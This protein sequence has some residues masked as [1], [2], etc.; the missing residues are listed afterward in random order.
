MM[1]LTIT[2]VI[3]TIQYLKYLESAELPVDHASLLGSVSAGGGIQGFCAGL[4]SA[5]AVASGTTKEEVAELA[6][7]SVNLAFCIG[8]YVDL[9]QLSNGDMSRSS[10]LAIR[11]KP[12][13][14]QDDIQRMLLDHADAYIAVTRD[15]QEVTVTSSISTLEIL[16]QDL[17]RRGVSAIETGLNGRYHSS[18]HADLPAK[19]IKVCRGLLDPRFGKQA[20]VRSNDDARI[21]PYEDA[22]RVTLNSILLHH[23]N[24]YLTISSSALPLRSLDGDPFILSI[25]SDAIPPSVMKGYRVVKLRGIAHQLNGVSNALNSAPKHNYIDLSNSGSIAVIGMSCRFPGA[26][27]IDE[28]WDLLI[29]GKSMLG[30]MPK[31]RFDTSHTTRSPE[32]LRFWGNF[33]R[34]VE[35]FDNKFFGKSSRESSSMDP[36][37]RILLEVAY[38]ALESSG[39]FSNQSKPRDI[40]CYIGAGSADYD[41][42]IGSHPPTAYSATGTLRAF[43]SGRISHYFGWSGPS[44]TL[45]TACSSS[46][47]AIHTACVA[48]RNGEC[49][50]ALTGGVA[51][52][53]SPG[54]Y[55]NLS[56]AHFLSPSGATKPFD[57]S[58]DGYC[59]GEGIGIILLKRLSDAL[60]D[61]D[62]I[63]GVIASSAI[64][65]NDNCVSITVPHSGSQSNLYKRA[66]ELA[67]VIPQQVAFVEAHG[68]GTPVGDPIEI[69]SIRGVFS[70]PG[71]VF[72]L[73]ISSVKGNIG[74]LEAA[75]GVAAIIK[76]LLQ[77]KH[78]MICTQ[79]SFSNLNPN[80]A[81]LE[82][83][84]MCIPITNRSLPPNVLTA[85]VNN[86][87]ASGSN[88]TIILAEPPPKD[89]RRINA[90]DDQDAAPAKFPIKVT[91]DSVPSMLRYISKL[92]SFCRQRLSS[93]ITD[94]PAQLL[95]NIAFNLARQQ[96][97]ELRYMLTLIAG[98]IGQL[99][100]VLQAQSEG[101][102]TIKRRPN[103][104]PVI[105]CFGGQVGQHIGLSSRLWR[106]SGPFRFHLDVCDKTL[107]SLG[108]PGIYPVIFQT[109]PI[110]DVVALQS[111]I[112][113]V[114]FACASAWLDSGLRVDAV[115]GHSLG[116]IAALSISGVLSLRDGLRLV[117]GR[118]SLMRQHWGPE[119]GVM[120]A[121][122]S[123][124][125]MIE[126]LATSLRGAD[127]DR[128]VE[129]ACYNSP[130]SI[131]TVSDKVTAQ[132][133]EVK[134]ASRSI[135]HKRLSV[136]N[137]FHSRFTDP[138][139]PHLESLAS[140]LIFNTARIPIETCT[141]GMSWPEPTARRVAAHTREPVFFYEA[142]QRIQDRFGPCTFLEA[143]S[144]SG[145]ISMIR[146]ALSHFI[147]VESNFMAMEL[148]EVASPEKLVDVT[149][150]LWNLGYQFNPW[151]F[152]R[153]Q[154]A[155]YDVLHLPP[156]Q[157]EK[158]K[159][160]LEL[161]RPTL[162]QRSFHENEMI[163]APLLPS[164]GLINFQFADPQ[165]QHFVV[166]SRSEEYQTLVLGHVVLG[167][168]EC[169]AS[170]Y[171]ELA[172]RAIRL[173]EKEK[174][175]WIVTVQNVRMGSR[176]GIASDCTVGLRVQELGGES[177]G[178]QI[179]SRA[180]HTTDQGQVT[181]LS[182]AT[183]TISLRPCDNTKLQ[184][185]LE[186]YSRLA[187]PERVSIPPYDQEDTCIKGPVIY[188]LFSG[189]VE[190]ADIYRGVRS[191]VSC[192]TKA[193]AKVLR[194]I[195]TY[196]CVKGSEIYP[197]LLEEFLQVASLHAKC[198]Y[199][200]PN[201]GI[202]RLS[203]I[204]EVQY[205]N[206][207]ASSGDRK[208]GLTSWDVV[209]FMS[210]SGDGFSSDIF[211]Y[212]TK[213]GG[214]V[215]YIF[216][217]RYVMSKRSSTDRTQAN[218]ESRVDTEITQRKKD[219]NHAITLADDIT[220]GCV[221]SKFLVESLVKNRFSQSSRKDARAIIYEEVVNMLET[222]AD[223]PRENIK[224]DIALEDLGVD[225]LMMIE[226]IGEI[227]SLYNVELQPD[228]LE[229]LPNLE[230]L[231][232]YLQGR[233][234]RSNSDEC[235]GH[236]PDRIYD[237]TPPNETTTSPS[238]GD[239]SHILT[240]SLSRPLSRIANRD[241]RGI[242]T[243]TLSELVLTGSRQ[244]NAQGLRG[245][246]PV[247]E[248]LRLDFDTYSQQTM[249]DGFWEKVY[250]DQ[251]NLVDAYITEAFRD[252]G[253]DISTLAPG[254]ALSQMKVLP[255]HER[256]MRQLC[257]ILVD[258]Q[259]LHVQSDGVYVRAKKAV[260]L[261][262]SQVLF[263]RMI[264]KYPQ[265][266]PETKLLNATG[267]QFAS[268]LMG[269]IDPIKL[270]F[271][272][273]TNRDIMA[274]VYENAP[275][276]Q[277]T[278]RLL[279]EFLARSMSSTSNRVFSIL[280]V[281][282]GTAGTAKYLVEHLS[283]RGANFVYTFTDL[284]PALVAQARKTF[285]SRR[286][287]RFATYDCDQVPP[288]ELR[289]KF[290]VIIAT[291]C[292]HAMKDAN[293]SARNMAAL[294]CGGG[295]LCLVEFT[296]GLYWF[297]LVYGLL[298][299]W[300]AFRGGRQH[301]L[302]DQWFWQQT[303]RAAGFENVSWT[304]GSSVEAQ[305]MRVICGFKGVAEKIQS[306]NPR[307]LGVTKRSG[308]PV[309]TLI[310]KQECELTFKAD[311]YFPETADDVS[312]RRPIALMF[313][314]G[315]HFLFSR[316]DIPMKHVQILLQRGF[317]PVSVDY[318]LCP[319]ATLFE[320]PIMDCCDALEWTR[321]ILPSLDLTGPKVT[322]DPNKLLA[323]GWSSGGQ[324]AMT[325][326][327]TAG[328]RGIQPPD[329]ILP[330][331]SLS[332]LEDDYWKQPHY[333]K[334]A[335]EEQTDI[336]GE[337]D[338]IQDKPILEYSLMSDEKDA[339]LFLTPKDDRARLILHMNWKAQTVQL[340]I[341]GLPHKSRV[342]T[343]DLTD[344]KALPFPPVEK[345]REC[346]PYWHILQGTYRTPTFMVHGDDDDWLPHQ[347]SEKSIAA[348][349]Q[350][351]V[352]CG[353]RIAK[354]C[355]HGFDLW[356]KE[357][358]VGDGW[359]A[360]ETA[361]DFACEQLAMTTE[362]L[363]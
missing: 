292:L 135:K 40:G 162:A 262:P 294:L 88:A 189:D 356:P 302:A 2:V 305:T 67:G 15:L 199:E 223:V 186:R 296:K 4:L 84:Q 252:L 166:D 306:S 16:R 114:Q 362:M 5:L 167:E 314:G 50:Q 332:D 1:T 20:L 204:D 54:P 209:C 188:K 285:A 152:H 78:R 164:S 177:W 239:A 147:R 36:Q 210:A 59:R 253:C 328:A 214:L 68:T 123:D 198:V 243:N 280:E 127:P 291:N 218:E 119:P 244:P 126:E 69:E 46:A 173:I 122:E 146:R 323:L 108:Y 341:R 230:S 219:E 322:I 203:G 12:P 351:S 47:V 57:A 297:D 107:R 270:L 352:P 192:G 103:E 343:D 242:T 94:E 35:C 95:A 222:V 337:L 98:D 39:Y 273:Q 276:C 92:E 141:E 363:V 271:A 145:V 224:E 312:K 136:T 293:F 333:P 155:S 310:W 232:G 250:P 157:F 274:D 38:Q 359:S 124:Q 216:G 153:R 110:A 86:Y 42:N 89:R 25:G 26:D 163:K 236:I 112:F 235:N 277:A 81:P 290:D 240:T 96:N 324:L 148:N 254:Q 342:A 87:G 93:P 272:N 61:G 320:G 183:G 200:A 120:I 336:W 21:I 170:L 34:D 129:I 339:A 6:A 161:A 116:Q 11:L 304:D 267:S 106:R 347:M 82:C 300:W 261:T 104:S 299:G 31:D 301:A 154:A 315:G 144:N 258:S 303:L 227:S 63:F 125:D 354:Q 229:Q 207:Y 278:T 156:Y 132:Q 60:I 142:V 140:T 181:T 197:Y 160:W 30:Q 66:V 150:G 72:P 77:I 309:E 134:L 23:S 345:V 231:V 37:Q 289:G 171:I 225:S 318:R 361:Y 263:D 295:V 29:Q 137:G 195:K 202:Y 18:L 281:G 184:G 205:G 269:S 113:S 139:I 130:N 330:F 118:A 325:L 317:L 79:A 331:Y 246:Q 298:E 55:E 346:N 28:F 64:N 313:H 176:L 111:A 85:C 286:G 326:G 311:V 260:D 319:E 307:S 201:E 24:W 321:K 27:S 65:Q 245:A 58:A 237:S 101:R 165:G 100:N 213:S 193:V 211:I 360:I 80:I 338:G 44:L 182:H 19:V 169:P 279:A 247:F 348:L 174:S 48:L 308:I 353:I 228:E 264:L 215:L 105:F 175:K 17:K 32:A 13:M 283:N 287:M 248:S 208:D 334:A 14:T 257:K 288:V 76:A 255:K 74:H 75:S 206:R 7:T 133:L 282:G 251:S 143:G 265:H 56:A 128:I 355:G 316:Q 99:S 158:S 121:V 180:N 187:G 241:A 45:D 70:G 179:L 149:M 159:H 90:A 275:M 190:Y 259:L 191:I 8:A 238:A 9:D 234:C 43:L 226:L 221:E 91:A 335:G 220:G 10:N 284:S 102:N 151:T 3:H 256:L 115:I 22:I 41:N 33:V 178:F 349:R 217:A 83:D 329:V 358:K 172:C 212:D 357:D 249:F 71:R 350:R 53:T 97:Q 233:G 109:D 194:P 268:C 327:Y 185:E 168:P 266:S 196:T 117:A 344:W 51:L 49:S 62:E 340:L 52:L 138:L 131:V 73:F